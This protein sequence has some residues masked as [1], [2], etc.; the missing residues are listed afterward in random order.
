[1]KLLDFFTGKETWGEF[2]RLLGQLDD[3]SRFAQAQEDDEELARRLVALAPEEVEEKPWRPK[4][5]GWTLLHEMMARLLDRQDAL[6]SLVSELPAGVRKRREL[7]P[8]FP[9]PETALGRA[10]AEIRAA[11][12]EAYMEQVED[13]ADKAKARWRAMSE[14]EKAE[15]TRK[16]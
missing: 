11:R 2:W 16:R 14:E 8:S 15:M 1:M 13:F 10:R 3:D 7:P 6:I 9:R 12:E 5:A 4:A